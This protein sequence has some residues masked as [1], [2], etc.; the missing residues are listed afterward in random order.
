MP[1]SSKITGTDRFNLLLAMVGYL[2]H[3]HEVPIET[4]AKQ[5]GITVE[6]A[7]SA[8]NTIWVSGVGNY[9]GGE[10]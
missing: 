9:F 10:L 8:V 4:L 6:E 7:D 2:M 1:K 5:F 3:N